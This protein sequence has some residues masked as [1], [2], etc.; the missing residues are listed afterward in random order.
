[1]SKRRNRNTASFEQNPTKTFEQDAPRSTWEQTQGKVSPTIVMIGE[2]G[3]GQPSIRLGATTPGNAPAWRGSRRWRTSTSKCDRKII[4]I[5]ACGPQRRGNA[6][7]TTRRLGH[8]ASQM[9]EAV[10]NLLREVN[11]AARDQ[12]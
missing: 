11:K 10:H 3:L 6:I 7:N 12:G 8:G 5:Q 2:D 9:R 1:M 4:F